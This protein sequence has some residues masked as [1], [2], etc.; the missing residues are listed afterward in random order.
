MRTFIALLCLVLVAGCGWQLRGASEALVFDSLRLRGAEARTRYDIEAALL[1]RQV[2]V[3]QDAALTL[4]LSQE[5]WWK[6]TLVVD[7]QG[8]SAG[9]E[10]R[11]QL[12]WQLLDSDGKPLTPKRDLL[13]TRVFQVDPANALATSDEEQM[14]RE[15]MR[16]DAAD[17]LMQQLQAESRRL[18]PTARSDQAEP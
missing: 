10:L 11:Y 17:V 1:Q 6:R 18:T 7:R 2:L 15:M 16:R 9:T 8:R 3:S 12:Q 4:Q 14:T 13:L 5:R